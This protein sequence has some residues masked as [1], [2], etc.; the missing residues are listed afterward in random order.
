MA[1]DEKGPNEL[2]SS[3][4][5]EV[6]CSIEEIEVGNTFERKIKHMRLCIEKVLRK[7]RMRGTDEADGIPRKLE[8]CKF[9]R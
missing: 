1:S 4:R 2:A 5:K 3:E 6:V 9:E 7:E 8:V